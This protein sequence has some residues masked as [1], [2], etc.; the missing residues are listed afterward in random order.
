MIHDTP[1]IEPREEQKIGGSRADEKNA[2]P[3]ISK[4]DQVDLIP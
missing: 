4:E 3:Y 2:S 1:G